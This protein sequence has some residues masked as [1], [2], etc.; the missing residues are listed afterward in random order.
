MSNNSINVFILTSKCNYRC[1]YC[2]QSQGIERDDFSLSR[3]KIKE[4]I[5]KVIENEPN[6]QTLFVLFGGEPFLRV[7]E[8]EFFFEYALS[9]KENCIFHIDTN[10]FYFNNID[11]VK[12][13]FTL[14][15]V[16]MNKVHILISFDGIGNYRRKDIN[17]NDTSL[18]TLKI[19]NLLV[20]CNFNIG[21]SYTIHAGNFTNFQS[22]IIE[23]IEKLHIKRMRINIFRKELEDTFGWSFFSEEEFS[24]Q[25]ES[26]FN[27]IYKKYRVPICNMN[28]GSCN[29]C[30]HSQK[31]RTYY[32]Q[33]ITSN[34]INIST[35]VSDYM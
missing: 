16:K 24:K 7:K 6:G 34:N 30:T 23:I 25:Y 20:K 17:G 15:A 4:Y 35:N 3:E 9:K 27:E 32:A 29:E 13:F 5:D 33:N 22:D 11:H 19:I 31:T 1:D 2:Y 14:P 8:M 26:F 10:G 18:K 28:C 12:H 21:I